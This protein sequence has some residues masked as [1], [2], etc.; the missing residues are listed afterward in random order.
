ML[1]EGEWAVTGRKGFGY[2]ILRAAETSGEGWF[3]EA[4]IRWCFILRRS[5]CTGIAETAST[6]N[7]HGH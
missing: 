3:H 6:S 1:G 2:W 5:T 7:L 4:A